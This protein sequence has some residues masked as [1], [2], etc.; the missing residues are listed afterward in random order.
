MEELLRFL[1]GG[2]SGI[3]NQLSALN[4]LERTGNTKI[5]QAPRTVLIKG[6]YNF[7]NAC[8]TL[9]IDSVTSA[10]VQILNFAEWNTAP[11]KVYSYTKFFHFRGRRKRVLQ[12]Y[13]LKLMDQRGDFISNE[14]SNWCTKKE[15]RKGCKILP[16]RSIST[17]N[18]KNKTG[19]RNMA[20][21]SKR[22]IK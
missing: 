21:Q 3:L 12:D 19:K 10:N 2:C 22:E 20:M 18:K 6:T 5:E 11:G 14:R 13:Y 16:Y 17:C 9:R 15:I 1:S 7:K 8:V 4:V